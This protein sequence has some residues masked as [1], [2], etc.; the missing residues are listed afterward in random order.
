MNN[1]RYGI[2]NNSK[3]HCA[4]TAV[5]LVFCVGARAQETSAST[6][7]MPTSTTATT[8]LARVLA[9]NSDNVTSLAKELRTMH[10]LAHNIVP[11]HG[12]PTLWRVQESGDYDINMVPALLAAGVSSDRI[13]KH[14]Q[15][16][17]KLLGVI[18][19]EEAYDCID[20]MNNLL[21]DPELIRAYEH[22][23]RHGLYNVHVLPGY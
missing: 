15:L 2:M 23:L 10:R 9:T 22:M 12:S 21:T 19:R 1:N 3:L 5:Y 13:A 20:R 11:T 8:L 4:L 18:T 14:S 7:V 6:V 16:R 17:L